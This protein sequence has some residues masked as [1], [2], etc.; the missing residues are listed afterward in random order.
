MQASYLG[1]MDAF[2]VLMLISLAAI[3]LAL[4]VHKVK[5]DGHAPV[6]H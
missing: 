4:T 6:G 5:L 3:P 2:W 1:Y